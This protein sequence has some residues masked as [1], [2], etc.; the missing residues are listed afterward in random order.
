MEEPARAAS[1]AQLVLS[2]RRG[3]GRQARSALDTSDPMKVCGVG[4]ESSLLWSRSR[5]MKPERC[6]RKH[7]PSLRFSTKL[8]DKHLSAV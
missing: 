5:L 7:G 1:S 6:E 3:G 2:I 4:A 8:V